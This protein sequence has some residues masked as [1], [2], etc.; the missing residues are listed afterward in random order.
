LQCRRKSLLPQAVE[1][2]ILGAESN[3]KAGKNKN[4][5][6]AQWQAYL[7]R[8]SEGLLAQEALLWMQMG[9]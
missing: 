5:R 4:K 1:R 2:I 9:N 8:F 7:T 3:I 6:A